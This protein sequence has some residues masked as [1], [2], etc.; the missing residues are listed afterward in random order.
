M[1]GFINWISTDLNLMADA[2]SRFDYPKLLLC[3]KLFGLK[4][5]DSIISPK[6]DFDFE[7]A[8]KLFQIRCVNH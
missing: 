8:E 3:N 2:L 5:I 6:M 4:I 1:C 7:N